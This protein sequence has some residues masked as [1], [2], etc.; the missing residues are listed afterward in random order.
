VTT[1]RS[2]VVLAVHG[3]LLGTRRELS[4]EDTRERHEVLR[5]SLL[6]GYRK[7]HSDATSSLDAVIAAVMV[8]EDSPVFNAA[9]GAIVTQSGTIELDAAIMDGLT[10]QAGAVAGVQR[11]RN[12][13]LAAQAVMKQTPCVLMVG[14]PADSLAEQLGLEMVS[15]EYFVTATRW[16]EYLERQKLQTKSSESHHGSATSNGSKGTVGAVAR[17]RCGNLAACNFN[18]RAFIQAFRARWR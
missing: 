5:E 7:L 4:E 11:V 13:I 16:N 15:R 12:P 9:H 1:D 8:L 6:A 18:R 14:E 17:D 2:K 3:G 10:S